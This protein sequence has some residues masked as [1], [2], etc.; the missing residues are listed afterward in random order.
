M[1]EGF[2]VATLPI[3]VSV[4]IMCLTFGF[5]YIFNRTFFFTGPTRAI[6][7]LRHRWWYALYDYNMILTN[8]LVGA[9]FTITRMAF[10]FVFGTMCI[11]RIDMCLLPVRAAPPTEASATLRW[12]DVSDGP[13]ASLPSARR[14]P[15]PPST[16]GI[17]PTSP[18]AAWTTGTTTP[19]AWSSSTK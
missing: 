4:Y 10:W 1:R 6:R 15:S 19:S 13:C 14:R 17:A 2:A 12:Q 8:T 18:S 7:W 16:L 3:L 5:Q 9:G 11:G